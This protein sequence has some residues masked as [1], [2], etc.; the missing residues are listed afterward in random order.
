[1]PDAASEALPER[2]RGSAARPSGGSTLRTLLVSLLICL[3]CSALVSLATVLLRPIQAENRRVARNAQLAAVLGRQPE[4]ETL[5]GGLTT[6]A[7]E[8]RVIDLQSGAFES[9]VDPALFD[10][11][12][13]ARSPETG[14]EIPQERDM[15]QIQRQARQA[16]VT[17]VRGERALQAIILPIYGRGYASIIHGSLAVAA[18][19]NTILGLV[20]SDHDE[21][22]GIGSEITE[23]EWTALWAGKKIRDEQGVLRIRVA[24]DEASA[25]EGDAVFL[26]DGISGATK[27]TEGVGNMARFWLGDDGYGPFLARVRAGAM[28]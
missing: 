21:T 28:R 23:P 4:L 12:Q 7:L 6:A 8:E 3:A 16:V 25:P 27:S 11:I 9:D 15:A 18:D 1:M 10:P 20:I 5:I 22:P 14:R 24:V 26:V 2:Q 19:G 17:V 13:A